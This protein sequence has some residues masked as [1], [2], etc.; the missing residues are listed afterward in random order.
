MIV[1]PLAVWLGH[2]KLE[3]RFFAGL[4]LLAGFMRL[5]RFLEQSCSGAQT[6]SR[7]GERSDA[8][9]FHV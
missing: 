6:L 9:R 1:Y 4:L 2:G 3:P 7:L 8:S 5:P